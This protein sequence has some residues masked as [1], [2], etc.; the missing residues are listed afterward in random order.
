[1]KQKQV[2]Q[3]DPQ[4]YFIG[5]TVADECPIEPGVFLYPA[6]TI[7][8][9]P[10]KV[11][12]LQLCKWNGSAW[13]YEDVPSPP[14]TP[15]P[16]PGPTPAEICKLEARH[17]LRKSDWSQLPDVALTLKNKASFDAYRAQVRALL[18][19]PV[20]EPVWPVIPIA[21]WSE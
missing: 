7:D 6:N 15:E 18:I 14:P 5:V 17:L 21:E 8:V 9:E 16:E 3:L 13:N 12:P 11:F 1:M 10:P 2:C 4:G 19:S 20:E